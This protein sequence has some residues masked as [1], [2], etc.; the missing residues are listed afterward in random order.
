MSEITNGIEQAKRLKSAGTRLLSGGIEAVLQRCGQVI[1]SGSYYLG[2]MA[3]PDIDIY[4]PYNPS[5]EYLSSFLQIGPDLARMCD[6][7]SLRFKNHVRFPV[8]SLPN[9]LYWGVRIRQNEEFTWKLDIWSLSMDIIEQNQSE[10]MRIEVKLTP[11]SRGFILHIKNQLLTSEGRTPVSSGYPIYC[12]VVDEG[13]CSI[14]EI[15]E[16][17]VAK[18]VTF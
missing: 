12:A 3:W 11:E 1:Y 4:T 2:L 18:G 7:V 16:Y 8:E 10:L 14:S 5:P 9:G 6:V 17:L 13:L 15:K